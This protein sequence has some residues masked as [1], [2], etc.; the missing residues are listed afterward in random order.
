MAIA[1]PPSQ[2]PNE[3][4]KREGMVLSVPLSSPERGYQSSAAKSSRFQ[5]VDYTMNTAM[6]I[7][8]VL[9]YSSLKQATYS[10]YSGIKITFTFAFGA[11]CEQHLCRA[12]SSSDNLRIS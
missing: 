3:G 4:C 5:F 7:T 2:L 1:G 10:T 11:K 9:F 8:A 6:F 12:L